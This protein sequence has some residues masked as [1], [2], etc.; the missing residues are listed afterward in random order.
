MWIERKD[1]FGGGS[2]KEGK[3]ME[4]EETASTTTEMCLSS[5]FLADDI[6]FCSI[7]STYRANKG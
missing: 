4:K 3:R 2:G 5:L 1:I 7:C 6:A